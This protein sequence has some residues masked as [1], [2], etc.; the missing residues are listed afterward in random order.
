VLHVDA[1]NPSN[2]LTKSDLREYTQRIAH[3]LRSNYGIGARGPNRDVVT[4]VTYGQVLYPAVYFGIIAAGG[5]SSAASPSSTVA[6]LARQIGIAE[7]RLVICGSEHRDVAREAAAQCGIPPDRVLLLESWPSRSLASLEGN[8]QAI[9]SEK[10]KWDTITDPKALEEGLITILW[11]S[12]TTGLPKGVML[13]HQNLVAETY[14]TALSSREWAAREMQKPTFKPVEF[15]TLAHLPLSHIAGLFS[16][17][18]TPFYNNGAVFWMKK[19]GWRDFLRYM[20]QHKVTVLFT[21]PTVYLRIAKSP[22]AAE[23][24]R[25]LSGAATGGSA[26]DG[27]LQTAASARLGAGNADVTIG[28]TWGLSETTG[29]CTGMPRGEVD[30]TGCISPPLPSVELR[31]VDDEYKDVDPGQPG[32]LL[33]RG[34][35]VMRGY[36]NDPEATKNAF[37]DGWLC[38]GD[39]AVMRDGK[40]YIIDRK[41]VSNSPHAT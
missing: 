28:Q 12:G 1:T 22:E 10:L 26:M 2:N 15:R 21:M 9:S 39:V 31:L 6:D 4:T 14:I 30:D 20:K 24:F 13:S 41:K 32:E 33:V 25:F 8:V 11:S 23:S 16:S 27:K 36:F 29:G 19:Y 17:T 37:H 40:F 35:T 7:S 3:G 5:V 18:I 34:P 38:T